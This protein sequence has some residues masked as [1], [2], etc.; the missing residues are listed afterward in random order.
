MEGARAKVNN[1]AGLVSTTSTSSNFATVMS[2]VATFLD[3]LFPAR[4]GTYGCPCGAVQLEIYTPFSSYGWIEQTTALCHCRDCI[5]FAKALD[6]GDELITNRATQMTQFYKSDVKV[7]RG[8]DQIGSLKLRETSVIARC[9]CKKC[10]TPLGADF[11][12]GPVML[13]YPSLLRGVNYPL[14]LPK[15]VLNYA[16][17]EPG[18]RR[19][20]RTTTVRQ[21]LLA[22]LFICRV[23]ARVI[24]GLFFGKGNAGGFLNGSYESV[25]LGLES[26]KD[27]SPE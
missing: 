2:F 11:I 9:Y 7:V 18:T 3:S 17:A 16:S 10:K 20:D 19:Y 4:Q 15:L 1:V 5:R 6:G 13:L 24:L 25:P 26:I 8:A 21:G 27:S 23:F 22:P 12:P 14:F